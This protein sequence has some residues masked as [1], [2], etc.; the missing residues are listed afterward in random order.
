MKLIPTN[1][2]KADGSK[3]I[4]GY[5]ITL[6]KTEVEKAGFQAGDEFQAEFKKDRIILKK[7]DNKKEPSN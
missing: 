5:K 3:L 6:A 2:Y 1:V 4:N 7:V